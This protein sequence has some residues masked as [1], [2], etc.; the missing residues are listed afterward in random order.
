METCAF[1]ATPRLPGDFPVLCPFDHEA[2]MDVFRP[3]RASK[4]LPLYHKVHVD[5]GGDPCC[6]HHAVG[7]ARCCTLA[8][9]KCVHTAHRRP[10]VSL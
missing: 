8:R 5:A 6:E 1:P 3:A 10:R 9:F 4:S 7:V 2:F